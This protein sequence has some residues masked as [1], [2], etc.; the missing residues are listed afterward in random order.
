MTAAGS[1]A[2]R[3]IV[4]TRPA[5]QADALGAAI[6]ARGGEPVLFPVLAIADVDAPGAAALAGIVARLGEYDLAV[7]VSPNAVEKAMAAI[8]RHGPWPGGVRAA[9]VGRESAAALARRG[10][11]DVVAPRDRADSE[12]LLALPELADMRGRRV[13]IFRGDGGRELLG[14][15][16]AARGAAVT[17]ATCYRRSRADA[18][19]A[20]LLA[21]WRRGAL[22]AVTVTSSEGLANLWETVG[23]PGQAFLRDTPLFAPH[24]RI[25]GNARALGLARVI[26]T[27][28]GDAGLVAGLET[29]F[30]TL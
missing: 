14:D 1:L 12:A 24:A 28:P 26:A 22:D 6:A 16:L 15:S 21:R 4:V 23:A 7:F 25:A 13:V 18:D 3:A 8:L 27:A 17:Y 2:G 9:T 30:A 19:P 5:G 10:V 20:P 11:T 29:F